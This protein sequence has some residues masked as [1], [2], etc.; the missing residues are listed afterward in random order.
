M[1]L[2]GQWPHLHTSVEALTKGHDLLDWGGYWNSVE[3][4][5]KL[6]FVSQHKSLIDGWIA[7]IPRFI[8][9][10]LLTDVLHT[11]GFLYN[12]VKFMVSLSELYFYSLSMR[13]VISTKSDI[14]V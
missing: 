7:F 5:S 8:P 4:A 13:L 10:F 9:C 11:L 3:P 12:Q 6:H 2:I 14:V 1:K